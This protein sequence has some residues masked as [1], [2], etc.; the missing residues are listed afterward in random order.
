MDAQ[1]METP[2]IKNPKK[3]PFWDFFELIFRQFY[4]FTR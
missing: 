3:I 2:K 1:K 4:S